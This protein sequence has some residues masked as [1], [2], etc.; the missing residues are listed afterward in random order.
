MKEENK[1]FTK[2]DLEVSEFKTEDYLDTPE[3]IEEYK[4]ALLE[5]GDKELIQEGL[6]TI[7]TAINKLQK[8]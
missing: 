8:I 7:K 1:E 2:E 3:L 6:R 5:T 4:K